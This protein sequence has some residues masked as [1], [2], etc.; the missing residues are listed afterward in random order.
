V[1]SF[2]EGKKSPQRTQGTGNLGRF[3]SRAKSQK[4]V[5][6]EL[7]KECRRS[8][9]NSLSLERGICTKCAK[10]SRTCQSPEDREIIHR[11]GEDRWQKIERFG[12]RNFVR[13]VQRKQR[14][15]RSHEERFHSGPL[16]P[17]DTWQRSTQFG[18]VQE[19]TPE[20]GTHEV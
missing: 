17:E 3:S 1:R 14:S 12:R 10:E 7:C 6:A 8:F 19:G 15:S 9:E 16:D 20:T 18:K 5:C 13:F 11:R 4:E 2:Q